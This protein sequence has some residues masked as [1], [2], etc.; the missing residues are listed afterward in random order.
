MTD[1]DTAVCAALKW[2]FQVLII[3]GVWASKKLCWPR[4]SGG[5]YQGD[6]GK[7]PLDVPQPDTFLADKSHRKKTFS[8]GM[9]G[10]KAAQPLLKILKT[11]IIRMAT[12]QLS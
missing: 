9:Y 3:A 12:F 1:D 5:R 2:G 6:Y 11:D 10:L 4:T 7:I 8:K